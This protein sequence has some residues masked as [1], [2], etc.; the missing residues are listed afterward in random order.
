MQLDLFEALEKYRKDPLAPDEHCPEHNG[1]AVE[2]ADVAI[3]VF[4]LA[5]ALGFHIGDVIEA[6]ALY[7][8]SRPMK[9][10]KAF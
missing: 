1:I 9:H 10:E 7:N 5:H 4:D 8:Q 6:K 2:L 3:R